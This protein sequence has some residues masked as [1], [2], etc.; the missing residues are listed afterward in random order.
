VSGTL[1]GETR[2]P[3]SQAAALLPVEMALKNGAPGL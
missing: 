3:V 1:Y 2:L